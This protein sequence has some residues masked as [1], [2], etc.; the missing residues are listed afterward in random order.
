MSSVR[1]ALLYCFTLIFFVKGKEVAA[2]DSYHFRD[3]PFTNLTV[4]DPNAQVVSPSV[5]LQ[6]GSQDKA[7]QD[8][9]KQLTEI[10]TSISGIKA[11]LK[12]LQ[13]TDLRIRFLLNIAGW[14]L[15]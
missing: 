8:I 12:P 15:G 6:L 5:Y 9:N 2:Q 14:L 11:D 4:P 3:K 7:I 1:V 10:S 13:E